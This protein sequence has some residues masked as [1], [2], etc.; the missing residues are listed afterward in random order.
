M[1][2]IIISVGMCFPYGWELRKM[3]TKPSQATSKQDEKK[4]VPN[5]P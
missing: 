4:T 1:L 2:K 5:G 3:K